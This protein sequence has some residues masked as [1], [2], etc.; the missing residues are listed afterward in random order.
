MT[1]DDYLAELE[2]QLRQLPPEERENAVSYYREYLE[3]SENLLETLDRLG[4]PKKVASEILANYS[5]RSAEERPTAKRGLS[6]VWIVIAAIFASPV[7]I[8]LA[9]LAAGSAVLLV[10]LLVMVLLLV[11]GAAFAFIMA[12]IFLF[13]IS[14]P[15][16]PQS[17]ATGFFFIGQSLVL[18]GIGLLIFLAALW[19]S[20][21]GFSGIAKLFHKVI[22][23]KG[24]T[25]NER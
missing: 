12:G 17:V 23:K 11:W 14:I 20:K 6:A 21:T 7:A 3:E 18:I 1:R 2:R 25:N 8:P 4:S 5:I 15:I 9:A 24:G 19:L 22:K 10:L 13:C 16:F